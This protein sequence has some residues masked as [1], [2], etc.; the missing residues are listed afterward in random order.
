LYRHA[1][2]YSE[3]INGGMI[4][5][6]TNCLII[7]N[8]GLLSRL[9][10][11][12][13]ICYVGGGFGDDGVHNVLEA[14]VYYK[15]VVFGPEYEKFIEAEELIDCG[16]GFSVESALELEQLLIQLL[17][18]ETDYQRSASSAGDYVYS[19]KGATGKIIKYIHE[20]RLLTS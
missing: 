13:T 10:K 3:I 5:P 11:Y 7:D 19:K 16:G 2:L 8:V 4:P 12:A 15:P 1:I 20:K 18:K 9:Y 6:A 14:A 17:K